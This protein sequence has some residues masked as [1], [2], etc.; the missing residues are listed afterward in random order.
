MKNDINVYI[1]LSQKLGDNMKN[2]VIFI[3]KF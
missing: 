1:Y 2:N 3:L